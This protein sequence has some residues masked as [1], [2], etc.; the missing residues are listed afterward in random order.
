MEQK[1]T[2]WE[3]FVKS[4][5]DGVIVIYEMFFGKKSK[6]KRT[7]RHL[8]DHSA[9]V[10]GDRQGHKADIW[11]TGFYLLIVF[12]LII[13]V[14]NSVGANTGVVFMSFL[15]TIASIL[16]VIYSFESQKGRTLLLG[17]PIIIAFVYA[18]VAGSGLVPELANTDYVNLAIL[19]IVL[20]LVYS[21]S[22]LKITD[23]FG[24]SKDDRIVVTER[25][26]DVEVI[27]EIHDVDMDY[28]DHINNIGMSIRKLNHAIGSV[29]SS[30]NGADGDMRDKI[31]IKSEWYRQARLCDPVEDTARTRQLLSRILHRLHRLYMIEEKL[32]G[33][34]HKNLKNISRDSDGRS[35]AITVLVHNGNPDLMLYYNRALQNCNDAL[36]SLP[37]R[38]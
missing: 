6:K 26:K 12:L 21:A 4:F 9:D 13:K 7:I 35:R 22:L 27:K 34:S 11:F 10:H 25:P 32:F 14:I 15:P 23:V 31:D 18:I 3:Q 24:S 37:I 19:N 2:I 20:S 36:N 5:D 16:L 28:T 29:Y 1:R 8:N 30:Q 38:N 17:I 33:E